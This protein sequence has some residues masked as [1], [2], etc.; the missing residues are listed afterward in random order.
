MSTL[1]RVELFIITVLF[2]ILVFRSI[3]QKKLQMKY[4]V[5]WI[6]ISFAMLIIAVFPDI[7]TVITNLTGIE[8]PSNFIYFAGIVVLLVVSF[9]LTTVVSKQSDTLRF[10][11]Q[12]TAINKF[13][14][15]ESEEQV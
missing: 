6:L 1:L 14:D 2:V 8:T 10:L 11:I 4:S 15:N 12:M 5:V 9:Y 13:L 3:N 7:I